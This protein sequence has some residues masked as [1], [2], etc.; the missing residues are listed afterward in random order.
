LVVG[1]FARAVLK[2]NF[3]VLSGLLAGSVTDPPALA[4]A[5]NLAGS[6]APAIAYATVYPVTMLLRILVAQ[7]LALAL[8]R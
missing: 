8:I 1:I 3:T 4:F 7:I 5:N 6:D 2:L